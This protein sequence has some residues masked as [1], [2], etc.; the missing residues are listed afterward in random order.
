MLVGGAAGDR[1]DGGTHD[2]LIFGDNVA[3]QRLVVGDWT[4]PRFRVLQRT[5][6]YSIATGTA[7]NVLVTGAW[8]VDPRGPAAWTDYRITLLDHDLATQTAGRKDFGNDV[9]AGG[10]D[11]DQIGRAHV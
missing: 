9:I 6:I 8:Q 1:V 3:L 10:P 7:G 5:A 2:D 11:D 4:N